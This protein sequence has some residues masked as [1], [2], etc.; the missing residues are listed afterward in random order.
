MHALTLDAKT[1]L[2]KGERPPASP[3]SV[4]ALVCGM[5]LCL[6]PLTGVPAIIAGVM[7][8]RAATADP[9]G[10]GGGRMATAGI[11]LGVLNLFLS[12]I[13]IAVLIASAF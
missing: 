13:A 6:G 7:G 5:L 3:A 8:R 9:N 1:G 10:T 4:V 12:A 11:A 2:P